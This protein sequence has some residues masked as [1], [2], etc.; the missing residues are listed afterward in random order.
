MRNTAKNNQVNSQSA[1]SGQAMVEIIV[2]LGVLLLIL[3]AVI[4]FG[5]GYFY[6]SRTVIANRHAVWSESRFGAEVTAQDLAFFYFGGEEMEEKLEMEIPDEEP[7]VG[8]AITFV[9]DIL[10]GSSG[11][12]GKTLRFTFRPSPVSDQDTIL[13]STH[14]LDGNTWMERRNPGKTLRYATWGLAG[15]HEFLG[16]GGKFLGKLGNKEVKVPFK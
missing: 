8:R 4:F 16:P 7:F 11:T 15:A 10:G 2:S 9:S 14:Y 13:A 12:D 3:S 1:Q 6:K 5:E